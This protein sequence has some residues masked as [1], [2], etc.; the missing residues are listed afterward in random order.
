MK[1]YI[2]AI[3]ICCIAFMSC[4]RWKEMKYNT[5]I[6]LAMKMQAE[7]KYKD[8]LVA[9]NEALAIDSDKVSAY[10]IRGEV[11]NQIGNY[12][13]AQQD[14]S[15]AIEIEP[16]N[17]LA[18]YQKGLACALQEKYDLAIV[19][20]N[21]VIDGDD[22]LT[23]EF[24]KS[25]PLYHDDHKDENKIDPTVVRYCRGYAYYMLK[26]DIHAMREFDFCVSKGYNNH[27]SVYFY[28]ANL[29]VA[30]NDFDKGCNYFSLANMYG[31]ADARSYID[32]Y[33]KLT[34]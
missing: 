24:D 3:I 34:K 7:G 30:H 2:T 14:L 27:G 31:C 16:S 21:K 23:F 28:M 32:K 4:D 25:N 15:K 29:F 11:D 20:Y 17:K 5:K 9:A 8:A 26:D 6:S 10:I 18:L 1:F 33:C 22:T 19:F 12:V 13:S